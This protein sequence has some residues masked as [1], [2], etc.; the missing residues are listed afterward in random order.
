VDIMG[1]EFVDSVVCM[2]YEAGY[3]VMER[4]WTRC[5]TRVCDSW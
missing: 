2:E 1:L 3:I 4:L 5:E